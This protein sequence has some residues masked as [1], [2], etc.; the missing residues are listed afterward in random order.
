MCETRAI[1]I[2]LGSEKHLRF[3]FQTAKR[4]TVQDAIAIAL[5]TGA[6][7]VFAL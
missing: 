1:V 5:K 7:I 2:A 6:Q 3:M 4:L